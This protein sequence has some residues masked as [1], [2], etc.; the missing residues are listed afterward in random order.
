MLTDT[1]GGDQ[2]L[3]AVVSPSYFAVLGLRPRAGRFFLPSEDTAAGHDPVVVLSH[4]FWQRRFAGDAG[5][6]G[7]RLTLAG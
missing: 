6:V 1:E 2:L 7:G 5:R 4:G 3:A